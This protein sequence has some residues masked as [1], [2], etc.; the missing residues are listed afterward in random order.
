MLA[1]LLLAASFALSAQG[2]D[3]SNATATP[4][5][6]AYRAQAGQSAAHFMDSSGTIRLFVTCTLANRTVTLSRTSS[7]PASSLTIWTDTA[8][9][10]LPA[11]FEPNAMRVTAGVQAADRLLDSIAFSRGRFAV[12]MPG[13]APLVLVPGPEA[14][15]VFEDCRN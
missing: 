1:S 4:G 9:R 13:F 5:G 7:A 10:T 14:A 15:R 3:Y 2:A 6:W 12:S 8:E 11:R